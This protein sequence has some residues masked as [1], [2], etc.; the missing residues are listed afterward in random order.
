MKISALYSIKRGIFFQPQKTNKSIRGKFPTLNLR[1]INNRNNFSF[2]NQ[3]GKYGIKSTE[4]PI[5]AH[6]FYRLN[7]NFLPLF[8]SVISTVY[9]CRIPKSTVY[10][11]FCGKKENFQFQLHNN[12]NNIKYVTRGLPRLH[13]LAAFQNKRCIYCLHS[14][15]IWINDCKHKF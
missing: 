1:N 12:M 3:S 9:R 15:G 10:R 2:G 5:L 13:S 14:V 4:V 7:P 6:F 11:L 8:P